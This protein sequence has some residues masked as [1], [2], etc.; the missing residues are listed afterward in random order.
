MYLFVLYELD[1]ESLVLDIRCRETWLVMGWPWFSFSPASFFFAYYICLH[2][3]I[4]KK[5]WSLR[6]FLTK[7]STVF[8]ECLLDNF[9]SI[10]VHCSLHIVIIYLF[11]V[12]ITWSKVSLYL[13]AHSFLLNWHFDE[14]LLGKNDRSILWKI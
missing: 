5:T 10:C 13:I 11:N 4:K 6:L 1:A 2:I 12:K 14:W 8:L 3:S 7:T 9:P